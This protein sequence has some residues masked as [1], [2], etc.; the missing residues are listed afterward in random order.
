MVWGKKVG[1]RD[2]RVSTKLMVAALALTALAATPASSGNIA[3][4]VVAGILAAVF[5]LAIVGYGFALVIRPLIGQEGSELGSALVVLGALAA[6]K[7]ALLPL[8]PGFGPDVSSY[9]AWALQIANLGP[10]HT[11]QSGYF[12]DYPP[13]YLYALWVAG[14]LANLV[15]AGGTTLRTI[16][17]SPAIFADFTL[18]V[19]VF[20][21]VR[22]E[23]RAALAFIA[24]I[25][26]A[27]NPALLFDTLVWGQSDSVLTFVT[28]LT[29]IAILGRQYE[30]GWALAAIS[31][32]V[33]P[34]GLMLLPVLAWWT[35][36]ETDIACW[37]RCA[38][39][40]LSVFGVGIL[41]FQIGHPWNW[42]L[43][44]Y[45]TTAA[46]YHETSVNA[47][48]LMALVGGLRVSDS[49]TIA[50]ISY[51]A[52]GMSMLVP[53]YAFVGWLVWRSRSAKTMM[54]AAFIT[55]FGFFLLA[56]RMHERYLYPAIVF[57]IPLALE[58]AEMLAV[59]GVISLTW[60]FNLA[61]VL[62]TLQT[63][64]FLNPRDGFAMAASA[65]NV[66]IFGVA[67]VYGARALT[68]G[69]TEEVVAD[70]AGGTSLKAIIRRLSERP[71]AVPEPAAESAAAP[72]ESG[73]PLPW[74]RVDTILIAALVVAGIATR[75]WRLGIPHE[76]VFDEVHFVGQARHYLHGET[77]DDP[78]P[79]LAKL[80]IAAGILL[81][82]DRPWG[83]RLGN[84][85]LGVALIGITYL[86]GRRMFR[87][88][89][90]GALAGGAVLLDGMYLVDSRTGVIDIVYLTFAALSY[91]LLFR[92]IDLRS[93]RA[94][95]N[96]LVWMGIA[97]GA[98]VGSKLYIPAVTFL[99][100]M[101]F[102]M[103]ALS[104][105]QRPALKSADRVIDALVLAYSG[106][107][108][109]FGVSALIAHV[110]GV[111]GDVKYVLSFSI[112][113]LTLLLPVGFLGYALMNDCAGDKRRIR[114]IL[115]ATALSGAVASLVYLGIFLPHFYLG[116]WRGVRDL[117]R[118]YQDD[119][120]N[121]ERSVANATHPYAS[122]WWS[123]PLMLRPIAYWQRW[124]AT[125][126]V[127]TVWGGN[128]PLLCW[129]ALTAITITLVH[130]LERR[131]VVRTFLVLGYLGYLV[132]WIPI[133]RTLFL[134]HYMGSVYLGYLALAMVLARCWDQRAELWEHAA[135]LF[136]MA[137]AFVL[138]LGHWW[139]S[140]LF[141]VLV[142]AY[143]AL[144]AG[145]SAVPGAAAQSDYAA[146]LLA[147]LRGRGVSASRFVCVTF[148]AA[149][150]VLF[151]Y[152]YPVWTA[153]PVSRHGYYSRMW[154]N[155]S[156]LWNWI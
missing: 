60:L 20:A 57:A 27:L 100:V 65:L 50:G 59:F 99:L 30:L 45:T 3:S 16:V 17:E 58:S 13:G 127:A 74:L 62:H 26:V 71:A 67:A 104:R 66:A 131:S 81:L 148:V 18:A 139:G 134:Y 90:A 141:G 10:A 109:A 123:W 128:N 152:F 156:G 116:W 154:L 40:G 113:A 72:E 48:N 35:M 108:L 138:G 86:L 137:P 25:M 6:V 69:A 39:V 53:L 118:Y 151:V 14:V 83:W 55:L 92:F 7:L 96:A 84:A 122:P 121:Y 42:I 101:G 105:E 91:L 88:R 143:L 125:G 1:R 68:R 9:Q 117:L 114:R 4:G 52:L 107:W 28:L 149:S 12:L 64:V 126:D 41:P 32:L 38:V 98:C 144:L 132:I 150:V 78:H 147:R 135:L 89:L 87:S 33:K 119:V 21:Y 85:I 129:G 79:P 19:A 111:G 82:G 76:I 44:L 102:M 155:G 136:T 8:F 145:D 24:L 106:V 73:G 31:V 61:Y 110:L 2:A 142:V 103:Y 70:A 36:L 75:F 140:S 130:A 29:V 80:V 146:Q 11:Y 120:I 153:I 97:L 115:G 34:Q 15:H 124:P 95:R 51:F 63:T 112:P 46:Y 54:Y 5:L 77:F 37:L 56:P 93:H 22:R 94:R 133:G 47:F 23:H 49:G 43:Q